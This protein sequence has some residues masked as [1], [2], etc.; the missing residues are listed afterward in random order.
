MIRIALR[1]N[2][3]PALG[4][5]T[6][7]T[8]FL[9]FIVASY[10]T[11]AVDRATTARDLTTMAEGFSFILPLPLRL[12]TLA[13]YVEWF[14]FGQFVAILGV[15]AVV[16]G[17]GASRGDEERGLVD[18]WLAAGVARWRVVTSQVSGFAIAS[19]AA[20]GVGC[21]AGWA[22]AA[23]V[24]EAVSAQGLLVQSAGVFAVMLLTFGV[25]VL[26][27]Q[28]LATRRSATGAGA[29]IVVSLFFLNSLSRQTD[30]LVP[31]RWMSPFSWYDRVHGLAPGVDVDGG[32]LALLA[33]VAL[34]ICALAIVAFARRDCGAPL[35]AGRGNAPATADPSSNP[36]LRSPMLASLWDQ[37]VALAVWSLAVAGEAYF[38][39]GLARSFLAAL[40]AA[41]PGDPY[42]QQ[43][44]VVT[45]SGHGTP[46][47]GFLG[48]EWFGGLLALGVAA[49]AIT[50]VARWA[51]DDAEGRLEALLSAPVS[52]ARVVVERAAS[53]LIAVAGLL[54]AGHVSLTVATYVEGTELDPGRLATAS[55][56][57]VPV[58]AVFGGVGA[59]VSSLR[60]RLAIFTL[61]AF[62][63]LTFM[64]P[65]AAPVV[66]APE[67]VKRLS[68]FDLYG[69]P[70]SDG[71]EVWRLA[72][73]TAVAAAGFGVALVAMQARDVG[74]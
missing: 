25:G 20:L 28:L 54:L 56:M 2:V 47:E 41:D 4:I 16:A 19:A 50:Q 71:L 15:W 46:Y 45:G 7:V 29:A 72:V 11:V 3:W 74:T 23:A 43:I 18:Q 51:G 1:A 8:T 13:G 42:T 36:L 62:A 55:L 5:V 26:A 53:L 73:L 49:F 70:L 33:L 32:A 6:L 63:F 14:G 40:A 52:R 9:P 58:A 68:V 57:L 10:A 30:A 38:M 48:F 44:R 37:R 59:A 64:I 35:L 69:F 67:W 66:R 17:T 22:T 39:L 24:G 61:S 60:P 12:D 27:G 65:F 34:G 31:Y 21:T